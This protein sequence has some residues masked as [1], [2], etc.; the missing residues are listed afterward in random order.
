MLPAANI[1]D[2]LRGPLSLHQNSARVPVGKAVNPN[3]QPIQKAAQVANIL[4]R[5][6]RWNQ[7]REN[8]GALPAV[9]SFHHLDAEIRSA[10]QTLIE[11]SRHWEKE[12]DCFSM[13]KSTK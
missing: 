13:F 4:H 9:S 10:T 6:L 8:S 5:T 11:D 2:N 7:E 12:I 3:L 1:S